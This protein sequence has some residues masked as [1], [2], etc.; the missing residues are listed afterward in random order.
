MYFIMLTV[1]EIP[2]AKHM[3]PLIYLCFY[4]KMAENTTAETCCGK[5]NK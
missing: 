5:V 3:F 4:L 2:L 1:K